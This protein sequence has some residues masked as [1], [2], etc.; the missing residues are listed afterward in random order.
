MDKVNKNQQAEDDFLE[1]LKEFTAARIALGRTGASIPL[2][3]SLAFNLAHAHARDA[4]YSELDLD[5]LSEELAQFELPVLQLHSKAA[6]REQYLQR[7]DLGRQL[8]DEAIN[9]LQDYQ[10]NY[11]I[12]IAIADGLSATAVNHHAISL[13]K[14]LIPQLLSAGLKLS[15]ICL[16]KHGR[17][18]IADDIGSHLNAK[19]S[20]I[21]IGERPGLSAADSMGAYLTFDPRPGLTDESRNC[22]S[23]IRPH[24]LSF[25]QASK[26]IFYLVQ[27]SF[28]RKISGVALKD[29]AGLLND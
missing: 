21:L 20:L 13:L 11:D 7:P 22:I 19:L 8:D 4:V 18:T 28:K 24:G 26:K 25:K 6:Y 29:N 1:P 14:I 23:N 5:K 16:V 3:Q 10:T 17:V 12:V 15:P 27:E 9:Q 2:K